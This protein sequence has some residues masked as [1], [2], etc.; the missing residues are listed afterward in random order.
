MRFGML[1]RSH[2]RG[3]FVKLERFQI[4]PLPATPYSG[5]RDLSSFSLHIRS[6]QVGK[7]VASTADLTIKESFAMVRKHRVF[8]GVVI[9]GCIAAL[10]L[11]V[12]AR[13]HDDEPP[14]NG[15]IAFARQVS[16]LMVNELV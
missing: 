5:V 16:D 1:Q 11:G 4:D 10:G 7:P 6:S 8:F 12:I 2:A 9:T 14:S 13:A 15:Q 3:G